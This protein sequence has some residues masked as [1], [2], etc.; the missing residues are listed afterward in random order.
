MFLLFIVLQSN[1]FI[2]Q[3][4]VYNLSTCHWYFFFI[5]LK[6][7]HLFKTIEEY[8]KEGNRIMNDWCDEEHVKAV[9]TPI[10]GKPQVIFTQCKLTLHE[11]LSQLKTWLYTKHKE[12]CYN[13]TL[14]II[15]YMINN[16][17]WV[18]HYHVGWNISLYFHLNAKKYEFHRNF[19]R[20]I[21]VCTR[22]ISHLNDVS[23][24]IYV[25]IGCCLIDIYQTSH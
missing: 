18:L 24:W 11:V 19:P 13:Y 7:T 17:T 2:S 4:I 15:L 9:Y 22:F 5:L 8:V 16:H 6:Q 12:M 23:F 20:W 3:Q 21:N 1:D 25:L 10:F 14:N